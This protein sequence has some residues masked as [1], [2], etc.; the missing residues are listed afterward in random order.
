MEKFFGVQIPTITPFDSNGQVNEE[1][2]GKLTQFYINARCSCLIPT[3]NNGEQPHLTEDEKKQVWKKTLEAANG[4]ILVA[5]SI[6]GNTTAQVIERAKYCESIG[7]DGVMV[8]PPYYFP[9]NPD[10]LY[11]HYRSIGESID[12]PIIIHNEPDIFKVD[13]MP[14]LVAKLNK[15]KTICLIKESTYDTTRIHSIVRLCGDAMT[16]IVAG[17]ATALESFVVG[18]KAWMTGLNNIVPELAVSMY[19]LAVVENNWTEARKVYFEKILP[20]QDCLKA[21]GKSVPVVK[22]ALELRDFP[23]GETRKPLSPLSE[24]QK[25]TVRKTLESI[26]VL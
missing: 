16:V 22:Y 17:G 10:D 12:I 8:G 13:L 25:Q 5:P 4:K 19:N 9:L 18:A 14:D 2:I 26:G 7:A 3:A 20:V 23:V 1:Q 6:S 21:I 24:E 15:T 11:A